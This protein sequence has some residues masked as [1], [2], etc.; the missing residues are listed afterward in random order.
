[1]S[2]DRL[3]SRFQRST[4]E[5]R[6]LARGKLDFVLANQGAL[7]SV[8]NG[9]KKLQA[10]RDFDSLLRHGEDLTPGQYNYID[11]IVESTWEG[12]GYESIKR[13]HDKPKAVLRYPKG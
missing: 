8:R 12:A 7:L 5:P 13:H 3:T 1:M 6:I 2:V 11:G 10:A 4:T 9:Q